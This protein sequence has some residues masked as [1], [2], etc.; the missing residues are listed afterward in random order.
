MIRCISIT[1]IS[2]FGAFCDMYSDLKTLDSLELYHFDFS[3]GFDGFNLNFLTV[4]KL[5]LW[6]TSF[7]GG[8]QFA[9]L[10]RAFPALRTLTCGGIS[11]D[12]HVTYPIPSSQHCIPPTLHSLGLIQGPAIHDPFLFEFFRSQP[13][14]EHIVSLFFRCCTRNYLLSSGEFFPMITSSSR[15]ITVDIQTSGLNSMHYH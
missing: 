3:H 4:T 11:F 1:S 5:Q 8:A 7:T 12:D 13:M 2:E 9:E 10:L 6:M 15:D 14:F